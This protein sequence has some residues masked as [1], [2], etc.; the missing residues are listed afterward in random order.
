MHSRLGAGL[1]A[2]LLVVGA[3]VAIPR[4]AAANTAP[5]EAAAA[6]GAALAGPQLVTFCESF[7]TLYVVIGGNGS[8][9][10]QTT[11]INLVPDGFIDCRYLNGVKDEGS[12]CSHSYPATETA[13]T[14]YYLLTASNGSEA[15]DDLECDDTFDSLVTVSSTIT[16]SSLAL[17][18]KRYQLEVTKGGTGSGDVTSIPSGV[19]C[20]TTCS[21]LWDFNTSVL[22]QAVPKPG[23]TFAGWTGSC[24]GQSEDCLIAIIGPLTTKA[25]FNGPAATT[26]PSKA[27]TPRP[28][29]TSAAPVTTLPPS[30]TDPSSGAPTT[31]VETAAAPTGLPGA[32]AGA[33][34]QPPTVPAVGE[35]S[36]TTLALFLLLLAILLIVGGIAYIAFRMGRRRSAPPA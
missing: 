13:Y 8:G 21:T 36:N 22:L 31:A 28:T 17:R 32:S 29:A 18:L 12:T 19:N 4:A 25:L 14:I 27:P 20:G 15:C 16:L 34:T 3:S 6:P 2:A 10:F 26:K 23:S 24:T 5:L 1:I 35:A 7:C 33:P 11:N 30:S 9:K